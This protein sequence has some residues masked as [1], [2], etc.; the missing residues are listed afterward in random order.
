VILRIKIKPSARSNTIK[1][2]IDNIY[3]VRIAAP[4]VEGKAN[5]ALIEFLSEILHIPKSKIRLKSGESSRIKS[6]EIPDDPEALRILDSLQ[7]N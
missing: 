6:L 1:K 5:K 2:S 7:N 3:E 4:P